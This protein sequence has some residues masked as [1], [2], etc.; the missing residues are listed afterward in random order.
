MPWAWFLR[1]NPENKASVFFPPE[2][3]NEGI[4]LWGPHGGHTGHLLDTV[5]NGGHVAVL[6]RGPV[7]SH[8]LLYLL[9]QFL[10]VLL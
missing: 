6:Q 7:G 8:V 1:E 3:Q 2:P 9:S 10:V 4:L 5:C